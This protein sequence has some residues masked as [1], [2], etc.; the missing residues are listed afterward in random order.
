MYHMEEEH[1][2]TERQKCRERNGQ[3]P[4]HI[5]SNRDKRGSTMDKQKTGVREINTERKSKEARW[6]SV[7]KTGERLRHRDKM[8]ERDGEKIE[9]IA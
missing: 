8:Q 4:R 3:G 1:R 2:E 6:R 9:R 7:D 5:G